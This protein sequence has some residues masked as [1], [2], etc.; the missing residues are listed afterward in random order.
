LLSYIRFEQLKE[1]RVVVF[2]YD[3]PVIVLQIERQ[4]IDIEIILLDI[5]LV[6]QYLIDYLVVM[7]SFYH[8][9]HGVLYVVC[10]YDLLVYWISDSMYHLKRL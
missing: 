4:T 9:V 10:E 8:V 3:A 7:I 2:L 1:L 6:L 5:Y